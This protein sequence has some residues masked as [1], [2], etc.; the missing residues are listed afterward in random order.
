MIYCLYGDDTKKSRE[1]LKSLLESLFLKKPNAGFFKLEIDS[2]KEKELEELISS[3]GL[4]EKK[5][6]VQID[7]LFEDK[8][9]SNFLVEKLKELQNSENI[10]IFIETKIGGPLLKKIEKYSAKVQEFSLK[11][12]MSRT[13]STNNGNF[14]LGEFN[15]FDL[16]TAFGK[17]DKKNLWMLYQSTIK[18]EIP[19][20]EVGG[21][22]F[23]QLKVMFQALKSKTVNQSGLKP[24]VF[25]KAKSYL[26]NYS[27]AELKKISS[28]L[29]FNYHNAR[30]GG[31]GLDL[32]LE[33]L[34]LEL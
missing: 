2:F 20:E 34:I 25:N 33:K 1:K 10:F 12:N 4:F 15:I 28:D 9:I 8:I 3:Q 27:E 14:N 19:S 21:I 24:F 5:Y 6:I 11:K 18:R 31:L 13:F 32:A 26:K 16:A 29:V 30:R 7:G 17:R 22:I 23:W